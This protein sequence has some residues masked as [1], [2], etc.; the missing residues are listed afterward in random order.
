MAFDLVAAYADSVTPF[1][2]KD[3]SPAVVSLGEAPQQITLRFSRECGSIRRHSPA[4]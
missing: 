1:Y 3:A 2:V 4:T